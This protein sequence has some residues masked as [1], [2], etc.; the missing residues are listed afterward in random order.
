[1]QTFCYYSVMLIQQS[2]L[3]YLQQYELYHMCLKL[4]TKQSRLSSNPNLNYKSFLHLLNK[5]N[6]ILQAQNESVKYFLL[7]FHNSSLLLKPSKNIKQYNY[8]D[9]LFFSILQDLKFHLHVK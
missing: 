7:G 3:F 9:L 8:L 4:V 6:K 5:N 2:V 1:M